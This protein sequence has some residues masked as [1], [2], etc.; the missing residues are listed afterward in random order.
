MSDLKTQYEAFTSGNLRF[1]IFMRPWWLN[2]VSEGHS[3]DVVLLDDGADIKAIFVYVLKTKGPFKSVGMPSL[4]PFLG[5]WFAEG[6]DRESHASKLLS[7][8]PKHDKFY[9]QMNYEVFGLN[10][11]NSEF[12]REILHT[13]TLSGISDS[14][15]IY[16][17][18][19]QRIKGEI[20]KAEGQVKIVETKDVEKLYA[21]CQLSYGRQGKKANFSLELVNN[22]YHAAVKNKSGTILLAE[23]SKGK[24][25]AATLLVWDQ[26]RAYYLLNGGDPALR[27]SGAN[28]LL[29]WEAI[30]Y[31]SQFTSTFDFEGSMI[32]GVEK[33]IQGYNP[34]RR[35]FAL[36]TKTNSK[37][38][39]AAEGLKKAFRDK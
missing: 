27:S 35:Q 29:M 22:I 7:M 5:F 4:T 18:F 38:V 28:S 26:N 9:M 36:F 32:P 19:K 11:L 31:C 10:F 21:L 20:K 33:Y 12:K 24:A 1:P 16:S 30:K 17:K 23:D 25:H 37:F 14:A 39:A 3:W 8:L 6:I 13:Y 34:D 15:N 2:A